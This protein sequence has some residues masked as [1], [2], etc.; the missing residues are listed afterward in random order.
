MLELKQL[1]IDFIL[2]ERI[3]ITRPVKVDDIAGVRTLQER[4]FGRQA[5]FGDGRKLQV[6]VVTLD[7]GVFGD[8]PFAARG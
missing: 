6:T 7:Q 2:A 4:M 8:H 3:V 1:R 5:R